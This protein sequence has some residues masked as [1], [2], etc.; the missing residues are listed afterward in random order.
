MAPSSAP[1]KNFG[2]TVPPGLRE[3]LTAVE[4]R[5]LGRTYTIYK[6][7]FGLTYF[8]LPVAH[9]RAAALFNGER[10]LGQIA[11]E[12]N[13]T[14]RYWKALP[15]DRA[16]AELAALTS[17]LAQSG[18]LRVPGRTATDRARRMRDLKQSRLF[19]LAV[20][21]SLFFKK[22]LLD[23]NAFLDRMFF[24][25]RWIYSPVVLWSAGVFMLLSLVAALAHWD[26]L[27]EQGANFFTLDNLALTWV[28][29]F[30]VK[31]F[32]E[33]GHA[34]TCKRHGGE[35]HEMGFMFIL[36]T[37]YLFCNVSDSWRASKRARIGVTAAGIG[38]ELFIAS[39]A[40]WGWLL[41]QP[42]LFNQIC[43]NTMVLCSVSTVLFNGNP[44][45]KFDG[46]YI[47]SDL[48]EI[49]NLRAKSNA[50]VTAWAQRYLLGLRSAGGRL[51]G[52][53]T[54]PLFGLYAVAAYFY[55]WFIVFRISVMIFNILEPYGLEFVSRTYVGLFLFVSL[56]LPLFRLGRSLQNSEEFRAAGWRRGGL[57]LAVLG[58]AGG[59]LF[60]IPWQETIRRGAALEHART[61][62]VSAP[63]DGFLRE[64]AVREGQR[65]EA[66]QLLGVLENVELARRLGDTEWQREALAVRHRAAVA[67]DSVEARLVAPVL[68]RQLRELDEEIDGLRARAQKLQLVAPRA[69]VVRTERPADRLHTYF[70]A[71]QPVFEIGAD[72]RMRLL[73]A[74]DE[75][76]ARRVRAGQEVRVRL[77]ALPE[78][79]FTGEI[80]AAP[81]SPVPTFGVPGLANVLGGDVPAE[82]DPVRGVVP[83][84]PH[85]E[86]EAI[87]EFSPEEAALLRA[88]TLGRA[89]IFVGRTTL[90]LWLRDRLLDVIDP[91]VRL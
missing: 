89:R 14:D 60:L 25:V 23:P 41:S 1:E 56:A 79:V 72:D 51:R 73:I 87:L 75:Q 38:V 4:Q 16:V 30:V 82:V 35:V 76:Q 45:M 8:R 77:K 67:E 57:A 21:Q 33:M 65:V 88:G 36:F 85:Y 49:P 63:L 34:F 9:A 66:G 48:L 5:Y 40:T 10:S 64:V 47:L 55:M 44:L 3:D 46:Y 6:N 26:Q 27:T 15:H 22:S 7:P 43:F 31:I 54:G 62:F 37:P 52:P 50:W 17:Q 39:L 68:A 12:L 81:V 32:H 74:L 69:G 42:G 78:R 91:S 29:F 18:L 70:Q 53:E 28:L 13:A 58:V 20:S 19:E 24:A 71:H 90:G 86:A 84:R 11:R 59:L 2:D 61:E 80:L 83:S